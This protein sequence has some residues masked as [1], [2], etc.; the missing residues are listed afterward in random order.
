M[1][2]CSRTRAGI[3]VVAVAVVAVMLPARMDAGASQRATAP[4]LRESRLPA[5]MPEAFGGG[6]VVLEVTVDPRGA[7]ARIDRVRV[8][9]PY[10]E[11]VADSAALWQFDPA[12]LVI[13]GRSEHIAA[14]VLVVAL[15]RPPSF[16]AG[17]AP[18]PPPQT[19]GAPSARLP[20]VQ[21]VVMPAYPPTAT[22]NGVVLVE[23]ELNGR[24]ESRAYRIVGPPSG[25]DSAALDA[26]RAWRFGT[27]A[28]ADAPD[29]LFVYAVVGFR[30]PLAPVA[31]QRR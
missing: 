4:R 29:P 9:P 1:T 6:E 18:G 19:L 15:F 16:Y 31:P 13:D 22:G 5:Q 21:S 8:T 28:A 14:Q 23:I 25:F 10:A 11:L 26:V 30:A 3:V 20:R 7:V 17:P 12:T 24:A 2:S 27:P